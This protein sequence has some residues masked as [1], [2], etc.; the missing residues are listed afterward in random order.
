MKPVV[1]SAKNLCINYRMSDWQYS[2]FKEWVL[3]GFGRSTRHREF[4]AVKHA[5]FEIEKGESVALLGHNGCGK[6]TILKAIAGVI[7]PSSGEI[8]ASGRIAPL[9]ELGAGFDGELSGKENIVLSCTMMGLSKAEIDDRLPEIIGF[10]ELKDF[11]SMPV[12]NYSSGMYA[13]LGFACATA[14]E[15]EILIVDEVLAVGDANFARKCQ[16]RIHELKS[17]GTTVVMVSHDAHSVRAFATRGIVIQEGKIEF[18]GPIH[19]AIQKHEELLDERMLAE[20]PEQ[21]ALEIKRLRRLAKSA[22]TQNDGK[23]DDIPIIRTSW[24]ASQSGL[25][26]NTVDATQPF[27]LIFRLYIEHIDRFNEDISVGF[28]LNTL[29]GVRIG[30][31]NNLDK[32]ISISKEQIT[33]DKELRVE[34]LFEKGLPLAT[35]EYSLVLGVHDQRISRNVSTTNVGNLILKNKN[36]PPNADGDLTRLQPWTSDI[37]IQY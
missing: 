9:I 19:E 36:D 31:C 28:G 27:S 16:E 21:E 17:N 37:R 1:I 13:R 5:T 7:P 6:S 34:F 32:F 8:R 24:K 26:S 11:I 33:P 30:G 15:P 29:G 10:A 23:I 20:R 35:G 18:D 12:K 2:S 25:E 22:E 4:H 14:V 3:S